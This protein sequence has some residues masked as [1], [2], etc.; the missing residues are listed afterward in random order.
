MPVIAA[1]RR[2]LGAC[3]FG[4]ALGLSLASTAAAQTTPYIG[5]IFSPA[6]REL[7]QFLSRA[8]AAVA[9][10]RYSDAVQELGQILSAGDSDDF[11]LSTPGS[12]DTQVS[13]KTQA[14]ELLGSMPAKGRK[15]Y[16]LQCG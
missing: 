14:L 6:P 13:L 9:E 5:N 4:L 16:E 1:P 8:Q 12:G 11:F 15:F 10:E 7:R 2:L 3:G